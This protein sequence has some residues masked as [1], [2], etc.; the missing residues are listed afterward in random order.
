MTMAFAILFAL[1]KGVDRMMYFGL[2]D[3]INDDKM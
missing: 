3:Q 1:S 2:S